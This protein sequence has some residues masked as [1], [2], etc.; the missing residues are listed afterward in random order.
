MDRDF[1]KMTDP[2]Y[3]TGETNFCEHC[4]R[5]ATIKGVL[6]QGPLLG[7]HLVS[8]TT[9]TITRLK[10][11]LVEPRVLS[12]CIQEGIWQTTSQFCKKERYTPWTQRHR[13]ALSQPP[14]QPPRP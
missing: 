8:K 10:S 7:F 6:E 14:S 4:T 9:E 3:T 12:D 5:A 2:A 11:P 1:S 13:R